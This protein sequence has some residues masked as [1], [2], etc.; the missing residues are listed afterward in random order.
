MKEFKVEKVVVERW[1]VVDEEG[2]QCSD[3]FETEMQAN[4]I[5]RALTRKFEILKRFKGE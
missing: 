4:M 3:W 5:R 2:F 1:I